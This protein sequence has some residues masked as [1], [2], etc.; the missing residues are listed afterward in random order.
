[1]EASAS[2]VAAS[3]VVGPEQIIRDHQEAARKK[4]LPRYRKL[5][6][7]VAEEILCEEAEQQAGKDCPHPAKRKAFWDAWIKEWPGLTA[8][9]GI[10]GTPHV[11]IE[12]MKDYVRRQKRAQDFDRDHREERE[13][14]RRELPGELE[15]LSECYRKTEEQ[16][17]RVD[18]KIRNAKSDLHR[19]D[20]ERDELEQFERRNPELFDAPA[21]EPVAAKP[22]ADGSVTVKPA[23]TDDRQKVVT[24]HEVP[25]EDQDRKTDSPAAPKTKTATGGGRPPLILPDIAPDD[26]ADPT[27]QDRQ[28]EYDPLSSFRTPRGQ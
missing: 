19:A 15:T 2:A 24:L 21:P 10:G 26:R 12:P 27:G 11:H 16:I 22:A 7:Q 6:R 1:M 18:M 20:Q 28:G 4:A 25:I 5:L 3:V 9:V 23:P 14:E 8:A 13:K 17:V